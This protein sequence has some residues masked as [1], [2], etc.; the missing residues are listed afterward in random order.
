MQARIQQCNDQNVCQRDQ[1]HSACKCMETHRKVC[2]VHAHQGEFPLQVGLQVRLLS[3]VQSEATPLPEV[4]SAAGSSAK[5]GRE[6]SLCATSDWR[7][8]APVAGSG[9]ADVRLQ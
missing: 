6:L 3:G 4:C 5:E 2:S 7:A 9:A 1:H 8:L